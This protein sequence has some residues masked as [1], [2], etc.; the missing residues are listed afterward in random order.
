MITS[1]ETWITPQ[2]DITSLK[3]VGYN[4]ITDNRTFSIG[5][6]VALY[7]K[8]NFEYHLRNDL[9]IAGVENICP[10]TEDMLICVIHIPPSRSQRYFI[11]EFEKVLHATFMSFL[12]LILGVFNINTLVKRTIANECLD[13]IHSEGI[14]PLIFVATFITESRTSCIKRILSNSFLTLC[15]QLLVVALL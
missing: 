12:C 10:D 3:I 5:G 15:L 13:L 8:S 2:D 4:I 11:D 7:L 1:S 9:K 6:G 14:N